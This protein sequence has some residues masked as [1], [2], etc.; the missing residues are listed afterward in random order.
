LRRWLGQNLNRRWRAFLTDLGVTALL[1]SS[2]ATGLMAA[3]FTVS[4]LIGLG[5]ALAVMLGANVGTTLVT[6]VLSFNISLVAPPLILAGVG[7]STRP[8]VGRRLR[9]PD[10]VRHSP[11]ADPIPSY[12]KAN[13]P[14][15]QEVCMKCSRIYSKRMVRRTS[16]KSKFRQASGRFTGMP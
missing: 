14:S 6:Q 12:A 7:T 15:G 16:M 11:E 8:R 13:V 9:Q 3:S 4:G 1:Q 2:T 10:T 5:L